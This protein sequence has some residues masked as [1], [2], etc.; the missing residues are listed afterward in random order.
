MQLPEG[1]PITVQ[2]GT[3][4]DPS[5]S[6]L[7]TRFSGPCGIAQVVTWRAGLYAAAALIPARSAFK[8]LV[9]IR[10]YQVGDIDPS[11]HKV[12][13]EVIPLFLATYHFRTTF[14]DY[15]GVKGEVVPIKEDA[16]CTAVAHVH[17]DESKM[18]LYRQTLGRELEA[19]FHQIQDAEAWIQALPL[20]PS[21]LHGLRR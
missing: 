2:P 16:R 8:L 13:R 19:F 10:G 1:L 12:Q 7:R 17:H 14:I 21:A 5:R 11:V 18:G 15:F 20:A 9:D 4:W 3:S 6:I